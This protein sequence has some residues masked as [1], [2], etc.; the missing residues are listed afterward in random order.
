[1]GNTS[2][3]LHQDNS[4]FYLSEFNGK[5]LCP[6]FH[7]I[8]KVLEVTAPYC[9]IANHGA[10]FAGMLCVL[11]GIE[12]VSQFIVKMSSKDIDSENQK[13]K[14]LYQN[15]KSGKK[16]L[17]YQRF[18]K[19]EAKN[20]MKSC[21]DNVFKTKIPKCDSAHLYELVWK[22]RNAHAHSFYPFIDEKKRVYG[23][24]SW[25][26]KNPMTKAGI[27]LVELENDFAFHKHKLYSIQ[28]DKKDEDKSCFAVCPHILFIYFKQACKD[29]IKKIENGDKEYDLFLQNYKRLASNYEFKLT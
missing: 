3:N 25:M 8:T 5:L 21:F 22:F 9:G 7:D 14:D 26:Y 19:S 27:S 29:F 6:L 23:A 10:N 1:M 2:K 24:I 12:T 15:L 20:F 28:K 11:V 18:P 16:L 17:T 4:T 13:A